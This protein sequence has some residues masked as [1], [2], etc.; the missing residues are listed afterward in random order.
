MA[1]DIV[2]FKK[3]TPAEYE[4]EAKDNNTLYF[5][6]VNGADRLSGYRLYLGSVPVVLTT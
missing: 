3:M 1:V 5:V 6:A 2:R 4:T